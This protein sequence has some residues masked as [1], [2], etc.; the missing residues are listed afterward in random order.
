MI[1]NN[2]TGKVMELVMYKLKKE[3]EREQFLSIA[4]KMNAMLEEQMI[5]FQN[6]T[7]LEAVED[8][9]WTEI[10][11]WDSMEHA[12]HAAEQLKQIDIFR[13]FVSLL[14]GKDMKLLHLNPVL[15]HYHTNP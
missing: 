9:S 8:D 2:S 3:T 14:D 4:Q 6:R 5:G 13:Q 7:L 11:Y 10:V 1:M 12:L 15:A